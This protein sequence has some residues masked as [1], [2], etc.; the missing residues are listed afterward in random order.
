MI[1]LFVEK[2]KTSKNKN[3]KYQIPFYPHPQVAIILS[4][5]QVEFKLVYLPSPLLAGAEPGEPE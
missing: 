1:G 3:D 2:Y 4:I 5:F